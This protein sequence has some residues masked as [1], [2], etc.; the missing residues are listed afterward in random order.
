MD[1]EIEN[2]NNTLIKYN[3][4]FD[5]D[6]G[7]LKIMYLTFFIIFIIGFF[8]NLLNRNKYLFYIFKLP[9]TIAH[10]LAHFIVGLIL[11]GKPTSFSVIPK[12]EKDKIV[13]GSVDF[14]NIMAI[15]AIPI[16][17]APILLLPLFFI[18]S[19]IFVSLLTRDLMLSE[20]IYLYAIGFG[21][22]LSSVLSSSIPSGQDFKVAFSNI[23]GV[24]FYSLVSIFTLNYYNIINVSE[25]IN[26]F[27]K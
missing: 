8:T 25:I 12:E 14:K 19:E 6:N 11:L 15:N 22:I 3:S 5:I 10:E 26:G 23:K 16:A 2:L 18:L 21:V 20:Y 13:L 1:K 17:F 27:I 4:L 24:I 7:I 9:G